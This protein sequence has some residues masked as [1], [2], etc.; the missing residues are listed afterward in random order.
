MSAALV[1]SEMPLCDARPSSPFPTGGVW[2]YHPVSP[3][4]MFRGHATHLRLHSALASPR[5]NAGDHSN[6]GERYLN[7]MTIRLERT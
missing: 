6:R 1:A 5:G 4:T 3:Y 2:E 7:L